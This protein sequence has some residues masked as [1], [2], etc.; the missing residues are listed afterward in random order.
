MSDAFTIDRAFTDMRLLGAAL[1]D[2][3]S[4]QV[5]RVVLKAAFGIELNRDEARAF[6]SVAGSRMPPKKRVRELW[7]VVGRRG[8]KSRMA[9]ALAVFFA[10]FVQHRLAAGE[11]GMVLV[12][13]ASQ[14]QARTVFEYVRGFLDASPT[15]SKEIVASS[16]TEI[17][18]ANGI[19]IAVHSN[20]FRT[21]RGRTLCACIMDEI[22]FWRD[23]ASALPDVETY[24]AVL[25]SLATTNGMLVAIST[26]YRKIGLLHQ[27]YR[28]HFG[29]DSDDT[30][31]VV[32]GT[33]KMFN[34]TLDDEV[35]AAQVAADPTAAP[36]EWDAIFRDDISAF[37]DDELIDAAISYGRPPEL[38]PVG[39]SYVAFTDAAGG[40][41]GDAYTLAIGHKDGERFIIDVVRGTTGKFDPAEVTRAYAALL[42]E[43]GIGSVTG[44][45]YG[46]EWVS[47]TW[48]DAGV[49]YN[50]AGLPKS[51][52][53]LETIPLFTRGL[54]RLPD[55]ARLLRE[56]RLLER[57]THRGGRDTVDHPRGGHDDHANVVCGVLREL[58]NSVGYDTSMR[59]LTE[60]SD[61]PAAVIIPVIPKRLCS[62]MTNEEYLRISKPVRLY[63]GPEVRT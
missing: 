52:I 1:G 57:Q 59:W 7:A 27:K 58:S 24:R 28:D 36:A 21:I 47:S 60:D 16:Q 56:F 17:T 26:P 49:T 5:W 2:Q 39:E 12:L 46:A 37:L 23:E 15:L 8:G 22:A 6:A 18:L 53:Y 55:H 40:T 38:P 29:Q 48:R 51:Q 33:A 9:G 19:V 41:G 31:L 62:T 42:K 30:T 3:R 20:S 25:P 43:Y 45:Y 11:R 14:A 50:R 54:V 63:P 34:P 13:A 4:W 61:V 35:I 44:D 32:Q 10:A